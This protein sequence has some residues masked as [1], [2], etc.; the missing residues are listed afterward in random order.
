MIRF[1]TCVVPF[2]AATA[3]AP[4]A[5]NAQQWNYEVDP[6]HFKLELDNECVRVV[7]GTFLPGEKSG[8]FDTQGVVVVLLT[9]RKSVRVQKADGTLLER[10]PMPSGSTYWVNPLG[11]ISL[12]NT[13][14]A[15]F[16]YLTIEAKTGCK[17]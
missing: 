8:M 3:L 9:E 4:I 11:R 17:N 15:T 14:D 1:W 2:S 6:Q 13:S 10:P 7:R 16:E 12:E 5:G